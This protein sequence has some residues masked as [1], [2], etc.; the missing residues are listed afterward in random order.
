MGRWQFSRDT[1]SVKELTLL[2]TKFIFL[3]MFIGLFIFLLFRQ[4][5]RY[6]QVVVDA[7]SVLFSLT[8][9]RLVTKVR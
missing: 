8:L 9:N 2:S 3:L 5:E 1:K 6:P 4:F 7:V